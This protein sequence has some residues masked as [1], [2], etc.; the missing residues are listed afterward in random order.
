MRFARQHKHI[1]WL[2]NITLI[3]ALTGCFQSA[4][5][6][7]APTIVNL[8]SIP[9]R[10]APSA[11]SFV[12]PLPADGFVPPTDDPILFLTQTA[13]VESTV[14]TELS[15]PQPIPPTDGS[16]TQPT[17]AIQPAQSVQTQAPSTPPTQS[18]LATPTALPTEGPCIH[19]VQPGEWMYSI[20]RK[21]NVSAEDL[22][23]ANPKFAGRPDALQPGDVLNIPNC[24]V[25]TAIP[26]TP[27]GP[28]ATPSP[29]SLIPVPTATQ[30]LINPP[31]PIQL[32]GRIY[33]VAP[34][35]TLGAI[36]RKFNTTVQALK[37][38]NNMDSDILH[39]GDQ[40][41]I[42]KP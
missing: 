33:T 32:S 42:P 6:S 37:E 17:Q 31:T 8:T 20:A 34:G 25:P 5:D 16:N 24:N 18:L 38:A 7:V 30:T 3:L 21:F 1:V 26:P 4:G 22:L 2:I 13:A 12:T 15:P 23:A 40:L 9:P 29:R 36:A 11:T 28:T 19:T 14:P 10:G 27:T 39:I 35:D 41:K